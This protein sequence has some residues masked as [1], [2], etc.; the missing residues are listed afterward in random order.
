VSQ[1]LTQ[2]VSPAMRESDWRQRWRDGHFFGLL[3]STSHLKMFLDTS[4]ATFLG[5]A[6]CVGLALTAIFVDAVV[7]LPPAGLWLVDLTLL[8]SLIAVVVLG[9]RQMW[10]NRFHAERTARLLEERLGIRNSVFT[11]AVDFASSAPRGDSPILRERAIRLA[12]ERAFELSPG[13]VLSA[14]PLAKAILV[15]A[16]AMLTALAGWWLAPRA[17]GMVLPRLLDPNG[18]HPPYTLVEFDVRI[19][20]EPVYHGKPATISVKLGGPEHV[21]QASVVF[22][23]GEKHEPAAMYPAGEG[24]FALRIERAEATRSFFIDTPQGRS[25]TYRL[26]V[27][28]VPFFEQI[29][30]TYAYPDYT[31]WPP[32]THRLD[33]RGLRALVGTEITVT[34]RSNLPLRAGALSLK[35]ESK[36]PNVKP[37]EPSR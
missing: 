19:A 20:P 16:A 13:K 23:D 17:F 3:E 18:D 31:A 21:E 33:G 5:L 15:V 30:V 22:L 37:G 11:N 1:V 25:E 28:E 32:Q 14:R 6:A 34:V 9:V 8:G 10:R 35:P 29:E 24:E 7:A 4:L 26:E 12:E 36:D 2:G 27:L